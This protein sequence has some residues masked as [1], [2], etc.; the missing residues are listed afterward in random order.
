MKKPV[1]LRFSHRAELKIWSDRVDVNIQPA[2]SH[3]CPHLILLVLSRAVS[4]ANNDG[5]LILSR[6]VSRANNNGILIL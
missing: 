3:G 5:I 4:R 2:L 1:A 6:A